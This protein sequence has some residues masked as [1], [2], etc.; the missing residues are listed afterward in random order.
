MNTPINFEDNIFIVGTRIRMI[1]DL[2][3]LD[4][5]PDLFLEKTLE[6]ID[7]IDHTLSVLLDNLLKSERFIEREEQFHN[8]SETEGQ[9]AEVLS[10]I[11]RGDGAVLAELPPAVQEKTALILAHSLQR[12]ELM[13]K[14]STPA[15]GSALDSVVSADELQELL[16]IME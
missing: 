5:E 10:S 6:D 4:A 9:F 8:L 12:R 7:F 3:I 1:R 15:G 13:E 2:L 11:G 14:S 16:K